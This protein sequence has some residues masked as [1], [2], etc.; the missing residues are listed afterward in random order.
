MKVN[1]VLLQ[2]F[3]SQE[4]L[5]ELN[6]KKRLFDK[7]DVKLNEKRLEIERQH[8]AKLDKNLKQKADRFFDSE[9][10]LIQRKN[11]IKEG[12]TQGYYYNHKQVATKGAKLW[13]APMKIRLQATS[14][15]IP[16]INAKFIDG[17]VFDMEQIIKNNKCTLFGFFFND[18]GVVS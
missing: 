11:L 10:N 5:K 13:E 7:L 6:Q 16:L 17:S 1:R 9:Q 8:E 14:P 18:F 2:K 4:L 15:Q 3:N 12:F